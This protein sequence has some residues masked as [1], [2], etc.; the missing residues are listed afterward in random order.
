MITAEEAKHVSTETTPLK[1]GSLRSEA[2]RMDLAI[3]Q[4]AYAG[5]DRTT[6][7][8]PFAIAEEMETFLKEAGYKVHWISEGQPFRLLY[9]SW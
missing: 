3:R 6:F 1:E 7:S 4:A 2:H 9:I 5:E 8:V